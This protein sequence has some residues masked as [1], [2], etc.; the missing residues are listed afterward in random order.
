MTFKK[1]LLLINILITGLILWM[2]TNIIF[3]FT[4]H[5]QGKAHVPEGGTSAKDPEKVVAKKI[6][7]P[8]HYQDIIRND[9]FKTYKQS[10]KQPV[11]E[12]K[13][14]KV[15]DLDLRL[16]GTIVGENRASHAIIWDGS[17]KKQEIYYLNDSVLG[18]RV[19]K[20]LSDR[21]I[22]SIKGKEEVL[23]LSTESSPPPKRI[24]RPPK[25]RSAGKRKI[26]RRPRI[27]K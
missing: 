14:I 5:K 19:M 24:S 15:T 6:K 13:E 8:A 20:I 10:P 11:K 9:I 22:L 3:T 18:A 2:A 12:E 23:L 25:K 7:K 16:Q 26:K 21:V 17:N 1:F 4:S 27:R